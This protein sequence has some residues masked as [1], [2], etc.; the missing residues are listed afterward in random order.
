MLYREGTNG[1]SIVNM[2][3]R[4]EKAL[5]SMGREKGWRE[6]GDVKL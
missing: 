5:S 2:E 4:M 6:G 1:G 3:G